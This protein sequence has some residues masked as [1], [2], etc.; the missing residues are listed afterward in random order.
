MSA[1]LLGFEYVKDMYADDADFSDV[2]KACDKTA[3]GKFYKHDGYLFKESKLYVPSY[4]MR[5]LLVRETHGGGLM[6]HF[7]VKISLD[8]LH[9]HF[10]WP[11]MKKDVNRIC[12]GC[13][14]CR[15]AKSKVLPHGLYTPLAV[16]SEPWVD[17]SRDFVL[18]L[19]RTK[20]GRDSIFVVVDR[21]SKIA[22]FIPCHKTNDATNIADLFFREIVRLHGV[23]RSIVSD[24]DVKFLSYFWKVL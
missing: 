18:G 1:K 6:G 21:F 2:Y 20:R 16:P 4:S 9:E 5:E 8:I 23:S 15:K 7:G 10:F 22:H 14:T 11:K 24:R 13:I 12:G 3:F 19:P 17:I